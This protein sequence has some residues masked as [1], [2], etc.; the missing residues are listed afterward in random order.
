MVTV[1][2][3]TPGWGCGFRGIA[4]PLSSATDSGIEIHES[5][6]GGFLLGVS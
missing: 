5:V 1:L 2:R 6:L 3:Y 4:L